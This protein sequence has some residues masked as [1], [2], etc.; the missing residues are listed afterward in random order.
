M[1]FGKF[2][3]LTFVDGSTPAIN[4]TNLNEMQR[5]IKLTDNEL[6]RSQSF[7]L[8]EYIKY[9]YYR[10]MSDI[11][12][13]NLDSSGWNI[14]NNTETGL[15]D[16]TTNNLFSFSALKWTKKTNTAGTET[17][18]RTVSNIDLT[19]YGNNTISST[20]D[21]IVFSFY[22]SNASKVTAIGFYLGTNSSNYF[23]KAKYPTT[24]WNFMYCKKSEFSTNGSPNWATITWESIAVQFAANAINEYVYYQSAQLVRGDA[25]LTSTPVFYQKYMGSVTGWRRIFDITDTWVYSLL[26]DMK[27]SKLGIMRLNSSD[28]ELQLHLV[29]DIIQF[30]SKFEFV[31]KYAGET[32][33]VT[34]FVDVNN[35]IEV[36]VTN[37]VFTMFIMETG[38]STTISKT[39]VY[40]LI[41][42]EKI[43]IHF[44]KDDSNMMRAMLY[45]IGEHVSPLEYGT[46]INNTADG[47]LGLGQSGS[48]SFGLLTDF[49]VSNSMNQITLNGELSHN[50]DAIQLELINNCTDT[51][52][53]TIDKIPFDSQIVKSGAAFYFDAANYGIKIISHELKTIEVSCQVWAERKIGSYVR[54]YIY[55]NDTMIAQS[56]VPA[57]QADDEAWAAPTCRTLVYVS[58][59]DMIYAY[60]TFSSGSATENVIKGSTYDNSCTLIAKVI[61]YNNYYPYNYY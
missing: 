58:K 15:S 27:T 6:K 4:A 17:I 38:V 46:S 5:I 60:I 41:K 30:T 45:K 51:G 53:N 50:I 35:Y 25:V 61:E 33:S 8:R 10:N 52:N 13:P 24:G 31:C 9:M 42:D 20:N 32:P 16:E 11:Y 40:P 36:Y 44:E 28:T 14:V 3:Q 57:R 43:Y 26:T 21:I 22:V 37:N 2:T 12:Y 1:E 55:K 18:N 34:W 47:C 7:K 49:A 56:I 19:K 48:N 23:A 39:L 54:L 59:D 29:C